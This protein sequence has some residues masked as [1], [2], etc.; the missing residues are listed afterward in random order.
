MH[1]DAIRDKCIQINI[2][3]EPLATNQ[4]DPANDRRGRRF[5]CVL[6]LVASN[7]V[8]RGSRL[9]NLPSLWPVA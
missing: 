2:I 6:E 4:Q 1:M 5:V 3:A 9:A 7:D 8:T